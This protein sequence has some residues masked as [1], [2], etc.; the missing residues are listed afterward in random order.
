MD[1]VTWSSLK[2]AEQ[3]IQASMSDPSLAAFIQ[4]TDPSMMKVDHEQIVSA[5]N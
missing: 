4:S 2:E 5:I 3:A 1:D